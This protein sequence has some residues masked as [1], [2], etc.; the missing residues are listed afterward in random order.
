[1]DDSRRTMRLVTTL[2]PRGVHRLDAFSL[3][4]NRRL[5]LSNAAL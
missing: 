1:M 3:K 5:T 2:R 4:L